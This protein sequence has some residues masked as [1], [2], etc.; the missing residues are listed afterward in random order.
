MKA[1]SIRQPYATR[2]AR[3]E[4]WIEYRTWRTDYRGPFLVCAGK[5]WDREEAKPP[6]WMDDYPLGVAVAV[7]VLG[8]VE[9]TASD[10]NL[11]WHLSEVQ[12]V[13]PFPVKGKLG[14]FEVPDRLIKRVGPVMRNPHPEEVITLFEAPDPG[15]GPNGERYIYTF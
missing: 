3:G 5:T 6:G 12:A 8:G 1:L 14:F 10:E 9:V 2:V 7:A 4:K 11:Y 15:T 13:T